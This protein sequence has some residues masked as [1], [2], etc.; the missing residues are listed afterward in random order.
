MIWGK[1]HEERERELDC[2][3]PVFACLPV[4][5]VDGRWAWL[6]RVEM[7]RRRRRAYD[8]LEPVTEVEIEYRAP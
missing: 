4:Q 7:R 8:G 3:R 5:L 6:Q 1:T 2:W